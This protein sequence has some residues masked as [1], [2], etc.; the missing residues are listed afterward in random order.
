MKFFV[1]LALGSF[2]IL[3]RFNLF[4]GINMGVFLEGFLPGLRSNESLVGVCLE[5]LVRLLFHIDLS[6]VTEGLRVFGIG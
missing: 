3:I 5:F 1:A 4:A 6:H 2:L